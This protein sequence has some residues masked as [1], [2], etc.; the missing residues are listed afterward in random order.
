MYSLAYELSEFIFSILF[1]KFLKFV[2]VAYEIKH[3][4]LSIHSKI[5]NGSSVP[6]KCLNSIVPNSINGNM[7]IPQYLDHIKCSKFEYNKF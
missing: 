7:F 3:P 2:F 4:I 6:Y 1:T 5:V